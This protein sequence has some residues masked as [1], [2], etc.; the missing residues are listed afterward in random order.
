LMANDYLISTQLMNEQGETVAAW[1]GHGLEGQAPTRAW[2]IGDSIHQQTWLPLVGLPN[3][4]YTVTMMIEGITPRP[5]TL[6]TLNL[7]NL[8]CDDNLPITIWQHGKMTPQPLTFRERETI[9]VTAD[10]PVTL[11]DPHGLSYSPN[12][13]AGNTSIYVVDPL[14]PRGDYQIK[15]EDSSVPLTINTLDRQVTMPAQPLPQAIN[16]AN[17]ISLL[18]YELPQAQLTANQDIPVHLYWQAMAIIPANLTMFT[19]VYDKQGQLWGGYDRLPQETYSPML[20][21]K[22]EVVPDDFTL[23]LKPNTPNGQYYV[24][25]GFYLPMGQAAVSLPLVEKGQA[26]SKTSVT[27][28]P[29]TITN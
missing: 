26:T 2:D 27:L 16:F 21:A 28:G 14:W 10:E 20:W 9:Q 24:D 22:G 4:Q 25:I 5:V 6:T 23:S 13:T 17:F 19:R 3:G 29:I 15:T 18:S 1:L 8:S 12:M 11:V 7:D